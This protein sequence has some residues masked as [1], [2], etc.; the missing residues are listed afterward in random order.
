MDTLV[1]CVKRMLEAGQTLPFSVYSSVKE[2][3]IVN[4]PIIKPM[5]ICVLD[6]RKKLGSL[7]EIDCPTGSFVILSNHPSI[8]MRNIPGDTEYLALIV[9]F[10][11]DDFNCLPPKQARTA[12]FVQGE[13]GAAFEK[14][15][16]QFVEWS[17]FAPP[18]M[19]AIRR[20]EILQLLYHLG[21]EQ[22]SAVIEPPS[23]SHKLYAIISAD[24]ANDVNADMLASQLAVSESTLRRKLAAEGTTLQAIKDRARLGFGLHLVQTTFDPIGRVAERCGYQSQSRFTDKFKQFFGLTPS[25]LRKT[26]TKEE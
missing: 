5:L 8:T 21:H 13:I 18:S 3:K 22:V 7:G 10:D 14:T 15:L 6:G 17:A 16:Q 25:E 1:A 12:P 20:Q 4:V 2:Q 11:Y 26:R 23:L 9:E 19:W 24:I